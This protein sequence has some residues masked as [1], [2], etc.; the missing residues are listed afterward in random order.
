LLKWHELAVRKLESK[1]NRN[2]DSVT[3]EGFVIM[4]APKQC[5]KNLVKNR[6]KGEMKAEWKK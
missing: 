2:V 1:M 3:G 4:R 5:E 6:M